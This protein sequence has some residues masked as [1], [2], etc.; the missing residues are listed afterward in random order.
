MDA[1]NGGGASESD[2]ANVRIQSSD[3]STRKIL[4][5][6]SP[7]SNLLAT[8]LKLENTSALPFMGWHQKA[9]FARLSPSCA[10]WGPANAQ[11]KMV[12]WHELRNFARD[13]SC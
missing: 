4:L 9:S 6:I 5:S 12:A 1:K 13:N 11:F 3:I 8:S 10:L 2:L 7:T